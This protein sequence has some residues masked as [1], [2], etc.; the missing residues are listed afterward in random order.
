[1]RQGISHV[2]AKFAAKAIVDIAGP[3]TLPCTITSLSA[4]MGMPVEG[5]PSI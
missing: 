4:R 2:R 1:M 5:A 3:L